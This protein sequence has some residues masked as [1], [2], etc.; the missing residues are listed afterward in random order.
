MQA[1]TGSAVVAGSAAAIVAAGINAAIV[2]TLS[3][4]AT[5]VITTGRVDLGSA[6]QSG[7]VSGL[8]AG[9]T[10]GV[11][12]NAPGT[13]SGSGLADGATGSAATVTPGTNGA[14]Q[15]SQGSWADFVKNPESYAANT[16]IRS[17]ISAAINSAVYGGSFGTAF[18]NG[19][20]AD[21]A[22]IG[23]NSIGGATDAY[24]LQNVLGHAFLGCAAASLSSGDCAGGA[25]GAGTSALLTPLIR[26]AI[27]ADSASLN[28]SDDKIRQAI[29][30]GLGTLAGGI[31]GIA[32]GT[33]G[34]SAAQSAEIEA[35]NN[36]TSRWQNVKDPRFQ[37]NVKALGECIDV[38]SCRMNAAYLEAQ[39]NG[40][41]DEK[42]ASLCGADNEC[43]AARKQERALYQ[44]AYTQAIGHEDPTIAARDYLGRLNQA[45]GNKYNGL[46][47][48]D[49]LQRFKQGLSDIANPLDAFVLKSI[50][51]NPAIFGA[52]LGVTA[53]DSD[54]G[55]S[56]RLPASSGNKVAQEV[57]QAYSNPS[58]LVQSRINSFLSQIPEN[59][60]GRITM[61]VAVVEDAN[62]VRS[63]LV[64]TSEPNGYLRPGVSLQYG[65]KVVAGTG[66]AE[67]DIISYANA[68]NLKVID[69]GA[70]R[71]VCANCQDT[72]QST[73]ANISTPLKNPPKE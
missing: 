58:Q 28:Y 67:A 24:S 40:L 25:V 9:V 29:T 42:I 41:N 43:V 18:L 17:G 73:G 47:L 5:Q 34:A 6:L 4:I 20:V 61:G 30:V 16:A 55:G 1:L 39:V 46:Q 59:S 51:G 44:G 7:A 50:V 54:G 2:G 21:A 22:A 68:N 72:I 70:T 65:D 60:K 57:F 64:S 35:L 10:S 8:V 71:P 14:T 69:I 23:A 15:L 38:V 49:A 11:L 37:A 62:G 31:A 45:Q 12:G 3:S 63:I 33:N 27:Y 26:D 52:V 13:S 48:D 36:A 56:G 32:A 66:H 19:V 53:L